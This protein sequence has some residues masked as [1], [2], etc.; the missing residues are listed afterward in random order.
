MLGI[1]PKAL[2]V[3]HK[4]STLSFKCL[5]LKTILKFY[6]WC[7]RENT[8]ILQGAQVVQKALQL[9]VVVSC[10]VRML[11]TGHWLSEKFLS[12]LTVEPFLQ[13][14]KDSCSLPSPFLP[15][16]VSLS[17]PHFLLFSL[18]SSPSP[19]L[20]PFPLLFSPF[21]PLSPLLSPL[22]LYPILYPALLSS[23]FWQGFVSGS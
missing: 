20:H 15:S 14:Q 7:K 9:H 5:F 13:P 3:L 16:P 11:G 8:H 21:L 23:S 1:K 22:L 17:S 2:R 18:P 6:M 10:V 12:F 4:H 19:L